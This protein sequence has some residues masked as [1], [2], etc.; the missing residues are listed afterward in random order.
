MTPYFVIL[1]VA[2]G[3]ITYIIKLPLSILKGLLRNLCR[4]ARMSCPLPGPASQTKNQIDMRK[5]KG[6]K[7]DLVAEVQVVHTDME[8]PTTSTV[9]C[10]C[11]SEL[12]RRGLGG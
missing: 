4:G 1:V 8:I 5:I 6:R 11:Q 3:P 2:S 7:S 12:R 9:R 10:M